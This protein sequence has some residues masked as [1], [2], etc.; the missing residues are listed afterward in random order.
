M[1]NFFSRWLHSIS[2]TACIKLLKNDPSSSCLWQQTSLRCPVCGRLIAYVFPLHGKYE[3][4][5]AY[6]F[7]CKKE[8][9]AIIQNSIPSEYREPVRNEPIGVIDWDLLREPIE[10]LISDC[11]DDD[12]KYQQCIQEY[13][14]QVRQSEYGDELLSEPLKA[15]EPD[16]PI[17]IE[18]DLKKESEIP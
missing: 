14:H 5:V 15:Q 16:E 11:W 7:A 10:P 6:P 17:L 4:H 3:L 12:E 13:I 2:P 9:Q 1:N 8:W 18:T